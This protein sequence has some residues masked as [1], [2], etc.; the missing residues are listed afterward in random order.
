MIVKREF[1][2]LSEN[3]KGD[4]LHGRVFPSLCDH[5]LKSG[6]YYPDFAQYNKEFRLFL[7]SIGIRLGIFDKMIGRSMERF[8]ISSYI[9]LEDKASECV[10]DYAYGLLLEESYYRF[11]HE[12]GELIEQLDQESVPSKDQLEALKHVCSSGPRFEAHIG[13]LSVPKMSVARIN[14]LLHLTSYAQSRNSKIVAILAAPYA[15]YYADCQPEEWLTYLLGSGD[16]ETLPVVRRILDAL[17]VKILNLK[18]L[19]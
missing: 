11:T 4:L 14:Y 6:Q 8:L 15:S 12:L 9:I 2:N 10:I 7:R 18:Y 3:E 16:K 17:L 13:G 1:N 5:W 19:T